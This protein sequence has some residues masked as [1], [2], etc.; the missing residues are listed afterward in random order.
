RHTSHVTRHTSLAS[1][2]SVFPWQA[3]SLCRRRLA[4]APAVSAA[5]PGFLPR[6]K[7]ALGCSRGALSPLFI[8]ILKLVLYPRSPQHLKTRPLLR[9]RYGSVSLFQRFSFF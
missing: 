6:R 4:V 9:I 3:A 1:P 8:S 7:I 2:S 5:C